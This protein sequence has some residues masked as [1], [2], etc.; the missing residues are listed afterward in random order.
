MK[1]MK[2]IVAS[3][4]RLNS[5]PVY[6]LIDRSATHS[7]ISIKIMGKVGEEPFDIVPSTSHIA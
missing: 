1:T 7:F 2:I 4:P 6:T 5:L 3:M